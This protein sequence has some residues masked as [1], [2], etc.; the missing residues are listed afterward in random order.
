MGSLVKD[1]I[2]REFPA[3]DADVMQYIDSILEHGL[4]DF[5]SARDVYDALGEIFHD[6]S[7]EKNDADIQNVCQIIFGRIRPQNGAEDDVGKCVGDDRKILGAPVNLGQM[8]DDFEDS[9][10]VSQ[11]IWVSHKDDSLKVCSRKLEKAEAKI[12][13]KLEKREKDTRPNVVP[14]EL[15]TASVSQVRRI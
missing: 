14:V 5:Q 7:E 8:A 2:S 6:V 1:I 9:L 3:V 11:S 10:K 13:Q 12:Q 15:Q 4:D